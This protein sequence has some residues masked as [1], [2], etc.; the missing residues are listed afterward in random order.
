MLEDGQDMGMVVGDCR[1]E[2]SED[3]RWNAG[4]ASGVRV[5]QAQMVAA[6]TNMVNVQTGWRLTWEPELGEESAGLRTR[7]RETV[8]ARRKVGESA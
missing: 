6:L 3:D 8:S 4:Y 1:D 5:G 2:E 7:V